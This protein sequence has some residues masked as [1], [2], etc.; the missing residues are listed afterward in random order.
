MEY[1][2]GNIRLLHDDCMDY[3]RTLPDNA[4]DL[5]VVDPPYGSANS[6]SSGGGGRFGPRFERYM[7]PSQRWTERTLLPPPPPPTHRK[8][9]RHREFQRR[10]MGKAIQTMRNRGS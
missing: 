3:M 6:E 1:V 7:E 5:A 2:N 8:G 10:N 4:F 9:R